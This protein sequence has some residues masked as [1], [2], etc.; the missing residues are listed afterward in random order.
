MKLSKKQIKDIVKVWASNVLFAQQ[1][2]LIEDLREILEI[3]DE[4]KEQIEIQVFLFASKLSLE[5]FK[6]TSE[7]LEHLD[8]KK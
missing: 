5:T 1:D 6:D 4:C 8:I 3:S 2:E 7:I